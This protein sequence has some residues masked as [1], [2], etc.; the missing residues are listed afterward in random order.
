MKTED[1]VNGQPY[2]FDRYD[3]VGEVSVWRLDGHLEPFVVIMPIAE[4]GNWWVSGV[5]TPDSDPLPGNADTRL[6]EQGMRHSSR[7]HGVSARELACERLVGAWHIIEAEREAVEA[8]AGN[9][10]PVAPEH[11][12]N[13]YRPSGL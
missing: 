1:I 3:M 4:R 2:L 12:P 10:E 8:E 7:A 6:H 5:N 13:E 11:D 9:A